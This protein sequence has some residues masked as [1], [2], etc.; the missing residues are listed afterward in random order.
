MVALWYPLAKRMGSWVTQRLGALWGVIGLARIPKDSARVLVRTDS[1]WTQ[2]YV[3]FYRD[4]L[5]EAQVC[6]CSSHF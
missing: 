4:G 3:L 6:Y 2:R 1:V 5:G